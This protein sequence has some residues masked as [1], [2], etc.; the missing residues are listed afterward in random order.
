MK[1]LIVGLGNFGDEYQHTR[2]NIG[3]TILDAISDLNNITFQDKR[4]AF[5][6]EYKYKGRTFVLIKPT[7]YVNLSGKAVNYWLQ[8]EKIPVE[9]LLVLVD[10]ISLPFGSLRLR[11]AGGDAGHNGLNNIST[12]LGHN[13]YARLRFGIGS[14]FG[15]G[16]QVNYVLGKWTNEEDKLLP[17]MIK[18]SG[19]IIQGFVTIGIERTMN[20]Y[21]KK[22]SF[23]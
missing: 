1:F 12:I 20:L 10:D 9:K 7:T 13:N 5:R 6:G 11:P 4:Y 15:K 2:H 18:N 16:T 8:K 21:N 23:D 19:K 22:N 14:E 3:Y 17:E